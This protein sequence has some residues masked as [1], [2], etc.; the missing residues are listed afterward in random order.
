MWV[1]LLGSTV[2]YR[3]T[4][5]RTRTIEA[6]EGDALI[7]IHGNGGHAEAY[8]RNIMRLAERFHVIA[9]DLAWHGLSS[10]P[11]FTQAMRATYAAQII[12]LMDS[13]GIAKASIEGESL[14]GWAALW[15]A[16]HHPDRIR[17]V[18]AN[19][20]AGV[21]L[22]PAPGAKTPPARDFAALKAQRLSLL[23]NPT[24]DRMRSALEWLMRNP[25][26]VTDELIELRTRIYGDPDTNAALLQVA[27]HSFGATTDE[28]LREDDLKKLKVPVLVLWTGHNPIQ[29][30][31]YGRRIAQAIPD[32][33][34]HC[35]EDAGHWPQW[36]Q[37]EEHDSVV[38]EFLET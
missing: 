13:M 2:H 22:T 12:D 29:D 21:F 33:S 5:F 6:G 25:D 18:V 38:I 23:R 17:K 37:P 8:S 14:G 32:S 27:E 7:L 26:R 1:D 11:P 10:N 15:T 16:I 34:F 19:T 35:I 30:L 3:G 24:R 9:I 28:A 4:R 36:E 20:T 31:A